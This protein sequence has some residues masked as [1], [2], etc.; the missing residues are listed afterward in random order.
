[1]DRGIWWATVLGVT[2]SDTTEHHYHHHQCY[3]LALFR[4][5]TGNRDFRKILGKDWGKKNKTD[6]F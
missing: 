5:F 3:T 6:F 2:E 4:T 1:M